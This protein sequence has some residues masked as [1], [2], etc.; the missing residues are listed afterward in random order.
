MVVAI[1]LDDSTER[2]VTYLADEYGAAINV[3]CSLLRSR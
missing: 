3:V 2:F 1:E